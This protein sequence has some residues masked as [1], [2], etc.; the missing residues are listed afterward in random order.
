MFVAIDRTSK[1]AYVELHK[2][3]TIEIVAQFLENL[4]ETVPFTI[5]TVL[6]DNGSQFTNPRNPKVQKELVNQ[7][8]QKTN[9][10]V[11]CNAFAAICIKDNIEHRLTLSSLD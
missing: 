5:H 8:D 1:Y 11:K 7:I 3:S 6:T 4:I 9:K 10:L 2:K